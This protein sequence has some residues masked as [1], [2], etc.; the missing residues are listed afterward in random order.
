[1]VPPGGG[2]LERALGPLLPLYVAQVGPAIGP[3]LVAVGA[4]ATTDYIVEAI[5]EPN[6]S[7]AEHYENVLITTRG[8]DARM[9]VI[10]FKSDRKIVIRDATQAGREIPIL[11]DAVKQIT[12]MPSLMPANLADQLQS[13]QEFLDLCRFVSLLGRPGPYAND[14]SPVLRKWQLIGTEQPGRPPGDDAAWVPAYAMVS[15]ALPASELS[16]G[17]IVYARGAVRVQVAGAI[18]L[19]CDTTGLRL[20]VDGREVPDLGSPLKLAKGRHVL[21]FEIDTAKRGKIGLRVFSQ[22]L[23]QEVADF[24]KRFNR[25]RYCFDYDQIENYLQEIQG[26]LLP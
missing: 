16:L 25:M 9:G 1:M 2:N 21:T 14:E 15:G 22:F 11:T 13:R 23:R 4:A 17:R 6:K 8:G 3:N 26:L 18:K 12:P 10:T 19:L 7:I 20:W 24:R 5:V